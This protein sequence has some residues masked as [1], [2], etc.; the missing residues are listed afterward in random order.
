MGSIFGSY[1]NQISMSMPMSML[2]SIGFDL[3]FD[4]DGFCVSIWIRIRGRCR[5]RCRLRCRIRCS[6]LLDFDSIRFDGLVGFVADYNWMCMTVA[7]DLNLEVDGFCF[8]NLDSK[9][10]SMPMPMSITM[11]DPI[12]INLF[13][14]D[15]IRFYG[16]NGFAPDYDSTSMASPAL[17]SFWME[18]YFI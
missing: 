2:F 1:W 6:F 17:V 5:C 4:F 14:F 11:S 13:D 16:F 18:S 10:T 15:W 8:S 7:M 12:I 9:L 3:S